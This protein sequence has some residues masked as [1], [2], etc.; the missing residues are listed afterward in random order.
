MLL[1]LSLSGMKQNTSIS[2]CLPFLCY[3]HVSTC[4]QW[5]TLVSLL[6]SSLLMPDNSKKK[7][8]EIHA[9]L[10]IMF[11]YFWTFKTCHGARQVQTL[12]QLTDTP[13][14][15]NIA[16]TFTFG[17]CSASLLKSKFLSLISSYSCLISLLYL[18]LEYKRNLMVFRLFIISHYYLITQVQW[19][20]ARKIWFFQPQEFWCSKCWKSAVLNSDFKASNQMEEFFQVMVKVFNFCLGRSKLKKHKNN[21]I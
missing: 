11:P 20:R 12:S 8:T 15:C 6:S 9:H 19:F 14:R 1:T 18:I 17:L 13:I 4:L 2:S 7:D 3:S 5:A 16:P 10:G 21:W